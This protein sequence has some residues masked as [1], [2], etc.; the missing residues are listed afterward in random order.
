[1]IKYAEDER[2]S[3]GFAIIDN[4]A[5]KVVSFVHDNGKVD[6]FKV[7]SA[8]DIDWHKLPRDMRAGVAT[9]DVVKVKFIK[10]NK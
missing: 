4:D 1:M 6:A 3:A 5:K 10:K 8:Q 2:G 7:A 9:R